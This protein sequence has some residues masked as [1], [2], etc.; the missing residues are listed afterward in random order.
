VSGSLPSNEDE[1][2]LERELETNEHVQV[3]VPSVTPSGRKLPLEG[4]TKQILDFVLPFSGGATVTPA[5]GYWLE[6]SPGLIAESVHVIDLHWPRRLS[7]L[8]CS[9]LASKLFRV[10]QQMEQDALA[11]VVGGR[12]HLIRP[13]VRRSA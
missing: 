7:R 4:W 8:E 6:S 13:E 1:Q 12:L 3:I 11:V 9:H 5:L 2:Q 10:A